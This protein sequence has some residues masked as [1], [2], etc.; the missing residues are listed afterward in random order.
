MSLRRVSHVNQY[1]TVLATAAIF[2]EL[3]RQSVL[4]ETTDRTKCTQARSQNSKFM[5]PV[6][7]NEGGR[8]GGLNGS[9][10][11]SEGPVAEHGEPCEDGIEDL[12]GSCCV[13]VFVLLGISCVKVRVGG[14]GEEITAFDSFPSLHYLAIC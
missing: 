12:H 13:I 9:E 4:T 3:G 6:G 2:S 8:G 14:E 5:K 1:T 10:R 11:M 7:L